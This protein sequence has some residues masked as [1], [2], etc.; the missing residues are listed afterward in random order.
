MPAFAKSSVPDWVRE[1]AAQPVSSY[2]PETTAAILLEDTTYT[3]APDGTATEHLREVIRILRPQGR[4]EGLVAVPFSK[5]QKLVSLHVWSISADGHEYNVKD[6]EM[7]EA[8]YPGQGNLYEDE[9]IRAANP[10]GRDPGAI[11]AYEYEQKMLPY[12]SEKTWFFEGSLPRVRQ[13]FTLQ[14]P[15]GYTYTTV[16]AHHAQVQAA[17]LE[18]RSWRWEMKDTP[19]I[20][21]QHMLY[22]PSLL[23][24]AGRMTVHYGTSTSIEKNGWQ[25]IG[26]WYETLARDRLAPTPEIAA[27]ANELIQGKTD[28]YD[29]TEAIAEFV[30]QQ[31]RYFAIE[32]GIGGYQP[33]YAE[34][35]FRNRYG[36]CKDEATLLSAMLSSVNIHAALLM[37]DDR[38]GVIDPDAPST[39]GN[40]MIAAIEIPKGYSSPR[41]RS[42]VT[43]KTGR[44]YLIFD[45]TWEKTPF[46]QLE[47]E[48][49]GSYGV[50]MEGPDSQVIRLPL[51]PPE[52]NRIHREG[53]LQLASDGSLKGTI[54]D[55]RFG[56][57][58]DRRR[59]L[60]THG[61]AKQQADFMDHVLEQDF[62]AFKV[63]N[64]KVENVEALNKDLITTFSIDVQRYAT[65]MGT[66]LTVRPRVLG[67]EAPSV[68]HEERRIPIDLGEAMQAHDEYEIEL[69]QGYTVDELP[70]P[71]KT[72][73][74]FASYESSTQL[75][76]NVLRYSR[77]MT[78]RE[79]TLPADKYA[80][81]QKLSGLIGNDE[82]GLA[83]L[84]KQ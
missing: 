55:A 6:N 16:W 44:K 84:K 19:A 66:L 83:V 28:F 57:V 51:L 23:S 7:V 52:L 20:N 54:T 41:L 37:V 65:A 69:P 61:D 60:Y 35:I 26:E 49:Q 77:T 39:V 13:V 33:H 56:D 2:S 63:S 29:K 21:M 81:L 32:M 34:E 47:H 53:K 38:R 15:A 46:G 79:V 68:D 78:I 74:G 70:E 22:R 3:V 43:A 27:K 14:L 31:V 9:R 82:Q 30:Q 25:G 73:L 11:V 50:L 10:P 48:L 75:K 59:A 42:V 45:P 80:D 18:N 4:E 8:G 12:V 76:G 1:A 67:Q 71:V 5:D 62:G 24:L 58:S 72:D 17:D 40:H 36:D 64:V